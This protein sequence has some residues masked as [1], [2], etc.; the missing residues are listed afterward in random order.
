MC[1]AFEQRIAIMV[2]RGQGFC[3]PIRNTDLF[4]CNLRQ[5]GDNAFNQQDVFAKL[6]FLDFGD[7][8]SVQYFTHE[9]QI[10]H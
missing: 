3:G 6:I 8:S 2:T 5:A 4:S 10:I 7:D 9:S 1:M